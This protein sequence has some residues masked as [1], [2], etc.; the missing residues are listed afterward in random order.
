VIGSQ[1]GDD[2]TTTFGSIGGVGVLSD[3]HL[4]IAD[5]Y[6]S[7]VR[8][9]DQ[10][11]VF[12]RS[13]GGRGSGPGEFGTL[14][15]FGVLDGDTIIVRDGDTYNQVLL[16]S[17][18]S[19]SRTVVGPSP[20]WNGLFPVYIADWMPDGSA[21]VSHNVQRSEYPPGTNL[22]RTEWHL[23]DPE[24]N[25]RHVFDSLP[26]VRAHNEGEGKAALALSGRAMVQ[27]DR[28]GFWHVFPEVAELVHHTPQGID[29]IIR[30]GF[31]PIEVTPP[32]REAYLTRARE[33]LQRQLQRLPPDRRSVPQ[34]RVDEVRFAERVPC[35]RNFLLSEEGDFWL[36]DYYSE[37]LLADH[38]WTWEN[39]PVSNHWTVISASGEWLGSV[40]LPE[41]FSLRVVTK[42]R[43]VGIIRDDLDVQ[44]VA[45]YPLNKP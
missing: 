38:A 26:E 36:Q 30:T 25:H 42:D 29:R 21:I 6:S 23:F 31:Q 45:V 5:S 1:G 28:T 44:Y 10:G 3:G 17:D 19:G 9:F 11:G 32:I 20:I 15:G 14:F 2:P 35:F 43:V 27:A 40:E 16:A 37:E 34:A 7:E 41:G 12:L 4:A 39:R 33:S 22:I 13:I 8:V 18:G 24:G